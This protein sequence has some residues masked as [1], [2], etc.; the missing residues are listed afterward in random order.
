MKRKS[1]LVLTL[2]M[3]VLSLSYVSIQAAFAQTDFNAYKGAAIDDSKIDGV[4]GNEW[5]DAAKYFDVAIDPQGTATVWT[6]NDGT[7]LYIAYQFTADSGDPWIAVQ[8][9]GNSC[10]ASGADAAL[11]GNNLPQFSKNGYVDCYLSGTGAI[12]ADA[13]QNGKGAMTVDSSNVVTVELKKPLNNGDSAGQDINWTLSETHTL[14]LIWNS[15]ILG[16]SGGSV[17]HS[18]KGNALGTATLR[19]VLINSAE[20]PSG[21]TDGQPGFFGLSFVVVLVAIIAIAAVV[22]LAVFLRRKK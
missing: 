20:K 22:I 14:I 7:N 17:S 10:M 9:G 15:N 3:V 16:S 11:F 8:L 19:T 6:K 1:L 12:R 4:I 2:L 18:T 21:A 5:D 13:T